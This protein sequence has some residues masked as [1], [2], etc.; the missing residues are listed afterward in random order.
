MSA[1]R[2]ARFLIRFNGR[3]IAELFGASCLNRGEGRYLDE[4]LPTSYCAAA[5]STF[6]QVVVARKPVYTIADM[7]ARAGRIVHYERLLSIRDHNDATHTFQVASVEAVRWSDRGPL[8]P[9]DLDQSVW[10]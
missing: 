9:F 10:P 1:N 5:H 4:V 7:R 3:R 6:H 8:R 2:N